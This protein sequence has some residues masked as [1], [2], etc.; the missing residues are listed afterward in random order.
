M[1]NRLIRSIVLTNAALAIF[2]P[3]ANA[4]TYTLEPLTFDGVFG[5]HIVT[6]LL[7]DQTPKQLGGTMCP[8]VKIPY[9]A[10]DLHI[11]EGADAIAATLLKAGDTVMGFS[12]GAAVV[13]DY[14]V[15]Y[16]PPEGV[17]FIVMGAITSGPNGVMQALHI[18]GFGQGPIPADTP[19]KVNIINR[20]YE[21]WGDF[22]TNTRAPGYGLA[23]IN[24]VVGGILPTV[25]TLHDFRNVDL[26]DPNNVVTVKGN[27]TTTLVP[28]KTLPIN[29]WMRPLGLNRLADRLDTR[30][31]PLIDAAYDRPSTT[32]AA[33]STVKHAAVKPSVR[34]QHTGTQRAEREPKHADPAERP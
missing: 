28:T 15:R 12:A 21:G 4:V 1:G 33:T 27:I 24:A 7:G 2:A 26:D 20:E 34:Q 19:A 25:D 18:P 30:M 17:A 5:T 11:T 9:I 22:P 13:T 23:V 16:T 10:D 32:S 14:L 8:C 31:R 3:T 29:N 6:D